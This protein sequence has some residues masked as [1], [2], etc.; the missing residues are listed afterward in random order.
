MIGIEKIRKL[1]SGDELDRETKRLRNTIRPMYDEKCG[2]KEKDQLRRWAQLKLLLNPTDKALVVYY[3]GSGGETIQ[4]KVIGA[5]HQ[6]DVNLGLFFALDEI[7]NQSTRQYLEGIMSEEHVYSE[8]SIMDNPDGKLISLS[9]EGLPKNYRLERKSQSLKVTHYIGDALEF[10]PPELQGGFDVFI[11][12]CWT[13]IDNHPG[14][15][16]QVYNGLREGG[17]EITDSETPS[18]SLFGGFD[19]SI[20]GYVEILPSIDRPDS[21]SGP[22]HLRVLQKT[23][24]GFIPLE[25]FMVDDIL[26]KSEPS[27]IGA[28]D[29]ALGL[30]KSLDK[31]CARDLAL[32]YTSFYY[33]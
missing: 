6:I 21:K 31:G 19:A 22:Y 7:T 5:S 30:L 23:K 14:F 16:A 28:K 2:F 29:K 11:N 18:T 24:C 20:F 12:K 1:L 25:I 13:D 17:Y 26:R 10:Y 15:K 3:P 33:T 27:D 9:K 4:A 32:E 8:I